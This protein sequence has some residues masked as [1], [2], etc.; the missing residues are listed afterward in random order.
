MILVHIAVLFIAT[1]DGAAEYRDVLHQVKMVTIAIFV[2]EYLLRIWTAEF[3]YPNKNKARAVLCFIFSFDGIVDLCTILQF[4][5]L[6]GFIAFRLLRV[7]RIF[8]LFAEVHGV[9]TVFHSSDDTLRIEVNV[10]HG[11]PDA[12]FLVPVS[13]YFTVNQG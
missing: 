1:F 7:V 9:L 4:S 5:C 11:I 12:V 10:H 13:P 8:R 2:V 3:L 6:Y